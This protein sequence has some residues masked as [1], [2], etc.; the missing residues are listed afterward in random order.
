[1]LPGCQNLRPADLL[2][3]LYDQLL[4]LFAADQLYVTAQALLVDG[5]ARS[6]SGA[7]AA[8]PDPWR[9]LPGGA[10]QS[11]TIP[12]GPLL[13]FST[14]NALY[15]EAQIVLPQD[16]LLLAFTD[17]VTEAGRG[18]SQQVQHGYLQRF[19]SGLPAGA[20]PRRAVLDLQDALRAHVGAGWPE[21]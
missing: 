9:G 11:W 8:V 15:S 13:G 21:D 3:F 1:K 4:T 16:Q 12:P 7:N 19:L 17:G 20:T 18:K 14:P 10:W 6:A 5:H 2:A